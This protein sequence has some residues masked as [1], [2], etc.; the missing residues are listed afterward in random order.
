MIMF[1]AVLRSISHQKF[2]RKKWCDVTFCAT[3]IPMISQFA[4][5]AVQLSTITS[6]EQTSWVVRMRR[7][8]VTDCLAHLALRGCRPL[9]QDDLAF[10]ADDSR[11]TLDCIISKWAPMRLF[12]ILYVKLKSHVVILPPKWDSSLFLVEVYVELRLSQR[13]LIKCLCIAA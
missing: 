7:P 2:F 10:S 1:I 6:L 9:Q 11:A 12:F 3:V 5:A 13:F 4:A 8:V